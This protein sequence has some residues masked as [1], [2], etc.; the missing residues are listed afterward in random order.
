MCE[1]NEKDIMYVNILSVKYHMQVIL[2]LSEDFMYGRVLVLNT[3][4]PLAIIIT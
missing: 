4:N 1:E 2:R 3:M